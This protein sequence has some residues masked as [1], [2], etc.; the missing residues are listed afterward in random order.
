MS[1]VG[2]SN[3]LLSWIWNLVLV[4]PEYQHFVVKSCFN[5]DKLMKFAK[6]R[7]TRPLVIRRTMVTETSSQLLAFPLQYSLIKIKETIIKIVYDYIFWIILAICSSLFVLNPEFY[8][9]KSMIFPIKIE[10]NLTRKLTTRMYQTP[11]FVTSNRLSVPFWITVYPLFCH[12]YFRSQ[13]KAN[14]NAMRSKVTKTPL[15]TEIKISSFL[16]WILN[17]FSSS[18]AAAWDSLRHVWSS[19]SSFRFSECSFRKKSLY[20]S[21]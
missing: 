15:R 4:Y 19:Y 9:K 8:P 1:K 18:A 14:E 13:K 21:Y 20:S 11:S 6:V 10:K 3:I 7:M 17:Q 12:Q 2:Y 5:L 16:V